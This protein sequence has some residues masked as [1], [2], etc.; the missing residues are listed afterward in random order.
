MSDRRA[1]AF[2]PTIY[3]YASIINAKQ[4]V[5]DCIFPVPLGVLSFH[6][7]FLSM[8]VP[9]CRRPISLSSQSIMAEYQALAQEE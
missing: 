2:T 4:Q 7:S 3:C 6:G 9:N 5:T 1:K 8:S